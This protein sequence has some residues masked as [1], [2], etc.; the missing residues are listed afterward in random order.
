MKHNIIFAAR[1]IREGL[2]NHQ[3]WV[4]LALEEIKQR[5]RRSIIGPFWITISMGILVFSMGPLYG[6]LLGIEMAVYVPHLAIG[7]I[8]W[9]YISG[10]INDGCNAFLSSGALITQVKLPLSIFIFKTIFRNF[11]VLGHNMIIIMIILFMYPPEEGIFILSTIFGLALVTINLFAFTFIV[12]V[13]STRFRDVTQLVSNILQLLFFVTPVLWTSEALRSHRYLLDWNI[14][15]HFLE[16]IR[17]PL[18]GM[19]PE[20]T[21]FIMVAIGSLTFSIAAFLT[22]ARFRAQISYWM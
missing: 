20:V 15:F 12:S 19:T 5:Y 6:N 8:L 10:V 21:S 4:S 17:K 9:S 22:F 7:I 13:I 3:V 16:V 1:D 11:I 2:L 14:F 18:M